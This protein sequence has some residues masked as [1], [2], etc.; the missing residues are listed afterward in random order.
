LLKGA[1]LL[2]NVKCK[3]GIA[4]PEELLE[5]IDKAAVVNLRK[6]EWTSPAPVVNINLTNGTCVKCKKNVDNCLTC[7]CGDLCCQTCL[8]EYTSY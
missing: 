8:I 3:C 1:G 5:R 6:K 7:K 4:I 2:G